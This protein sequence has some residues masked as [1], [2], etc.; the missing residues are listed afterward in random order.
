MA[1]HYQFH[2]GAQ[3]C[4]HKASYLLLLANC[5][6]GAKQMKRKRRALKQLKT[7]VSRMQGDIERKL[8]TQPEGVRSVF[9]EN[10]MTGKR[11]S[12]AWNN[13]RS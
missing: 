2:Q 4:C 12:P 7:L 1:L 10:L 8:T 6:L 3:E 5:Y 11:S 13:P 9:P